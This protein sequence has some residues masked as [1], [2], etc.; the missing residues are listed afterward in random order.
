M[1]K[2]S[3][4]D[5][6]GVSKAAKDEEIK[7]AYRRLA[8]K[9]HPDVSREH[10]AEHQFKQIQEAY[11]T[12]KT[13]SKRATYD[14]AQRNPGWHGAQQR[15]ASGG[16]AG[17]GGA[18]ASAD[19]GSGQYNDFFQNIFGERSAKAKTQPGE[20]YHTTLNVALDDALNGV[21]KA[22]LI[23]VPEVNHHGDRQL[24]SKTLSVNIP[25]GI[26][27]GQKIR[28]KAQ[29]SSKS[30]QGPKGDLYLEVKL[31]ASKPYYLKDEHVYV[32]L[33]IAPWEAALGCEVEVPTLAGNVSMKIEPGTQGGA[34]LRLKGRGLPQKGKFPATDAYVVIQII[35]PMPESSKDE[36]F[37]RKM[38]KTLSFNPRDA[39][40]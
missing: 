22:V 16:W 6:L 3:Y 19:A 8:R 26:R 27:S 33:P 30:H 37:Y 32:D 5:I 12:L 36:A 9:Y 31:M 4:Y 23:H 28:L 17:N 39:W 34:K 7:R 25:Q 13:A 21:K 29:G 24:V 2:K 40:P 38:E 10:N 15:Q 35:T 18:G 14:E 20:D 1:S 11:E